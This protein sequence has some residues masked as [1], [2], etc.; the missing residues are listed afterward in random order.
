MPSIEQDS[1]DEEPE[2]EVFIDSSVD[3]DADF[4]LLPPIPLR[5]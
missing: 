4:V 2:N 3:D 1:E 5:R